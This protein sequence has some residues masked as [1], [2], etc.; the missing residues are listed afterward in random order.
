MP[1]GLEVGGS[2]R[3]PIRWVRPGT[4]L[5]HA[6]PSRHCGHSTVRVEKAMVKKKKK[7]KGGKRKG[8]KKSKSNPLFDDRD[9]MAAFARSNLDVSMWIM[10]ARTKFQAQIQKEQKYKFMEASIRAECK[11]RGEN[12]EETNQKVD[13]AIQRA[14]AEESSS[15]SDIS[16]ASSSESDEPTHDTQAYLRPMKQKPL[17][18]PRLYADHGKTLLGSAYS[19]ENQRKPYGNR[20][21]M[22]RYARYGAAR[23]G[24]APDV[25]PRPDAKNV[26]LARKGREALG[27][28]FRIVRPARSLGLYK[29]MSASSVLGPPPSVSEPRRSTTSVLRRMS[30]RTANECGEG[31]KSAIVDQVDYASDDTLASWLD[32]DEEELFEQ[33][34]EQMYTNAH[35]EEAALK[36][37]QEQRAKEMAM[38]KDREKQEQDIASLKVESMGIMEKKKLGTFTVADLQREKEID[39]QLLNMQSLA[40]AHADS[41]RPSTSESLQAHDEHLEN[42]LKQ[43]HHH[44]PLRP[45]TPVVTLPSIDLRAVGIREDTSA[46]IASCVATQVA[47]TFPQS[48]VASRTLDLG[49]NRLKRGIKSL[50]EKVALRR[51]M[52]LVLH[53]NNIGSEGALTL[54]RSFRVGQG[55]PPSLLEYLDLGSNGIGDKAAGVLARYLARYATSLSTLMLDH[56]NVGELGATGIATLLARLPSLRRLS[57]KRNAIRGD[58]AAAMGGG[59]AKNKGLQY[60]DVSYNSLGK[61]GE[62]RSAHSWGRGLRKHAKLLHADF[63]YNGF[64]AN[65]CKIINEA[66]SKNRTCVGLHFTGNEGH[67]NPRGHLLPEPAWDGYLETHIISPLRFHGVSALP[68]A[69]KAKTTCWVC[70]GWNPH[71][72]EFTPRSRN[73]SIPLLKY[74]ALVALW[75]KHR[76][77]YHATL[78]HEAQEAWKAGEEHAMS[79]FHGYRNDGR[80]S[81]DRYCLLVDEAETKF[82]LNPGAFPLSWTVAGD[83]S[84]ANVAAKKTRYC[85]NDFISGYSRARY[86]AGPQKNSVL[87]TC[88]LVVDFDSPMIME[89]N[90]VTST[91]HVTLMC[92]P[93]RRRYHFIVDGVPMLACDQDSA[94][95]NATVDPGDVRPSNPVQEAEQKSTSAERAKDPPADVLALRN[96]VAVAVNEGPRAYPKSPGVVLKSEEQT[97]PRAKRPKVKLA[98]PKINPWKK[99]K[100]VF[101]K[102]KDETDELR[103]KAFQ[104]DW[105]MTVKKISKFI[106]DKAEIDAIKDIFEEHWGS[107]KNVFKFYAVNNGTEPFYLGMNTFT[108]FC[109]ESKILDSSTVGLQDVDTI[110]IGTNYTDEKIKNS[111]NNPDRCVVRYQFLEGVTRLAQVKYGTASRNASGGGGLPPSDAVEKLIR[112]NILPFAQ[113]VR[114]REFRQQVLYDS[115]PIDD[116]LKENLS[117]FERVYHLY[118]GTIDVPPP[119][120]RKV[121]SVNEYLQCIEDLRMFQ[122]YGLGTREALIM[123]NSSQMLNV[124]EIKKTNHRVLVFVEFLELMCRMA[125]FVGSKIEERA[126]AKAKQAERE[127]QEA[128]AKER[129]KKKNK[130]GKKGGGEPKKLSMLEKLK[131]A[132]LKVTPSLKQGSDDDTSQNK[133]ANLVVSEVDRRD[134]LYQYLSSFVGSILALGKSPKKIPSPDDAGD[135]AAHKKSGSPAAVSPRSDEF[136]DTFDAPLSPSSPLG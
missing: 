91:F 70:G 27:G 26:V 9:A 80:V 44:L 105:K 112:S 61:C 56:N 67:L 45:L 57:V 2:H 133:L 129:K 93:G 30:E 111:L 28:G 68:D 62:H 8:L 72:F 32:S 36:R 65:D 110:F 18:L 109:S 119:G 55:E 73:E 90:R 96:I 117:E 34:M 54:A 17:H 104:N 81:H 101:A 103:L 126:M 79:Q 124:C 60:L 66:L 71:R 99:S 128:E 115:L 10:S 23:S 15:G 52:R 16:S 95:P 102:F 134:K 41:A 5:L 92:P 37:R 74:H 94:L 43:S 48:D 88:I 132:A 21:L 123:F 97:I 50:L 116:L 114:A 3:R 47:N 39:T 6:N 130:G 49:G 100:S 29:S 35:R 125:Y 120:Q 4:A 127:R 136:G 118:A 38:K 75:E 20:P 12:E 22:Q 63:S 40:S 87:K 84:P 7:K 86:L 121:I 14:M 11:E 108:D 89:L 82:G 69:W 53:D 1:E 98:K 59:L 76:A 77:A 64:D 135:E 107:L 106:K 122:L 31:N 51:L 19:L 33:R 42:E 131:S 85:I 113:Q 78:E 83:L 24:G 25:S 58:G 46:E 13:R